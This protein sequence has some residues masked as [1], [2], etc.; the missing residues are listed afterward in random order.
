MTTYFGQ[1]LFSKTL[2]FGPLDPPKLSEFPVQAEPVGPGGGGLLGRPV[3]LPE[4]PSEVRD[5]EDLPAVGRRRWSSL[6]AQVRS[7]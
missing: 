5:R 1:I 2:V 3:L 7:R 6:S 4:G